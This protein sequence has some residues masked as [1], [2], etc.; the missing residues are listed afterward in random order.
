MLEVKQ[1]S[2]FF[3]REGETLVLEPYGENI[4]RVRATAGAGVEENT[5][6]LLP[7]R[8]CQARAEIR[9]GKG[10]LCNGGIVGEITE[11]GHLAFYNREGRLL[12]REFWTPE[13]DMP[14]RRFLGKSGLFYMETQFCPNPEEHLYGMG[15]EAHD[16]FDLKGSI[17][18]LCQ[19][20]TKSTIPFVV[21]SR[22]YG[23]LWN[24]PGIG[25]A[26]FG[27]SCT[28]WCAEASRQL[29][30]LVIA[31]GSTAEIV[32]RYCT[33]SGYAPEFPAWAA[34]FWQSRLRYETQEELLEVA[35]E[36]KRRGIPLSM[37]V[38]DYFHWPQQGEWKF[39]P[40]YW[41]DPA[42]MM[43][44]L[45]EMGVR[46]LVSIWPTV[47]PRS[48]NYI[49]MRDRNMLV[50]TERGPGVLIFCRG[51]E[52]YYDAT[53][54]E[55][56]RF[57]VD[58]VRK[59][60]MRYGIKNFWLDEAEP[61]IAPYD[62]DNLR[63]FLGNGLEV[64]NLYPYCYAKNFYDGL[65][66]AGQ[67]EILNLIRCAF[68][69]S[70]RF[71][72]VLWSGDIPSDFGSLRRQIKCGLNVSL[73]GIP[74]WTTDI[75]GFHG[76]NADDPAY[77]ECL[78]RWFQFGAFCPVFRM[79]GFRDKADRPASSPYDL[80]GFCATGGANE[81]WSFGEEAY[82]VMRDYIFLRKRLRPYILEQ[83]RLA[84]A[85]GTPVMRPLFYD[86]PEEKCFGIWDQYLFGPAVMVCPVCR[87]GVRER[88][89]YLPG[90]CTWI[91]ARTG[92]EFDGGAT[93]SAD[94]PLEWMP[95]FL[96]KGAGLSPELFAK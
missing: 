43:R 13:R 61:E 67:E 2:F 52:T 57:V 7:P 30:Y 79:H 24:N 11:D 90:G 72:V 92:R 6:T 58:K 96:K 17:I 87:Q 64:S 75:G 86:F 45:E 34:G 28:R 51:P 4:L 74:W 39:D 76:G 80:S 9:D 5:W 22:G 3:C 83:M 27:T 50:R 35:R 59:N 20:N 62:Y 33:L 19:Q 25:R 71:G 48:E 63:Y 88:E 21:S 68:I 89:V 93:V 66:E 41:P 47:D 44:E 8:A 94:A 70:Q 95:L 60:Y 42:A 85:K 78:V 54:P 84:S 81:I 38:C 18:D 56:G 29:D 37:I 53:N 14:G 31:G 15:Q 26:E 12:L 73:C 1:S 69:G 65:R 49:T 16:L 82:A 36:Y 91:D 46:L 55:A 40:A 77:R 23:F 10:V 32:E